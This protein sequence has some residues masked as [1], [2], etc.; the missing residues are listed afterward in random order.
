MKQL[1]RSECAILPLVLE[2]EWYD[3]IASGEKKE[4]YRDAKRF[5]QT[6][7][8]N[9]NLR[10]MHFYRDKGSWGK[11]QV[12]AFSRGYK[13]ADMF[14]TIISVMP[15]EGSDHPEWGEPE[16]PHYVIKLDERVE[17]VD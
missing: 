9:W 7:I 17:L 12:V 14:F 5:W 15:K 10:A 8:V 2:G 1:K 6:R 4:E 16:T 11:T 3:M 13:K